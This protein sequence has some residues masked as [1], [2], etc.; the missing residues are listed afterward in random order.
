[1]SPNFYPSNFRRFFQAACLPMI[2]LFLAAC[3]PEPA[4][5]VQTVEVTRLIPGATVFN[6][7]EVTRLVPFA[8]TVTPTETREVSQTLT[9]T[10]T[11]TPTS[12]LTPTFTI[13]PT[14]APPRIRV[15]LHSQCM[16]GPGVGFLYKY[17]ILADTI[18]NAIGQRETLV[19][20][21]SG[22]WEPRT[23][24]YI[25]AIG[26]NNPCWISGSLIEPVSG[27]LSSVPVFTSF[28]PISQLYGPVTNASAT[29]VGDMVTVFWTG[30]WMTEDDYRGY[31][32]E[33]WVCH[34]GQLY[35][36][37]VGYKGP[38]SNILAVEIPDE[39]GC[40]EP[41]SGR[42]YAVEKHGYTAWILVPWPHF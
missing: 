12:T 7:V 20:I 32:V 38:N 36:T 40:S 34:N 1:M 5:V 13:T 4:T 25:Q 29:R 8:V 26:G 21:A 10:P 30:I 24:Y 23:W 18:M 15:T 33:T 39:P 14:Y 16:F 9:D 42:V 28:L 11:I 17:D 6:T 37:P 2:I 27:D 19:Q 3:S 22:D 35:Y 31:L 41:S